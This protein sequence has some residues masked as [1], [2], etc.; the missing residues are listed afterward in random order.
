MLLVI[1]SVFL[2]VK[3]DL[4]LATIWWYDL[5]EAIEYKAIIF[6]QAFEDINL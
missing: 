6:H 3:S 4:T 2:G 1:N 5:E